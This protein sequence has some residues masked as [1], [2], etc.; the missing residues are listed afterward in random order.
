[1]H[2]QAR[3]SSFYRRCM[4]KAQPAEA[5]TLHEA[6]VITRAQLEALKAAGK[7]VMEGL[8][9]AARACLAAIPLSQEGDCTTGLDVARV[10]RAKDMALE[11][12]ARVGRD[13]DAASLEA[14]STLPRLVSAR[15]ERE[16]VRHA[17]GMFRWMRR[18][19]APLLIDLAVED[20][21]SAATRLDSLQPC[22]RRDEEEEHTRCWELA[23]GDV[24]ERVADRRFALSLE[25]F[26]DVIDVVADDVRRNGPCDDSAAF[27]FGE[28]LVGAL[29]TSS[30]EIT[31][32]WDWAVLDDVEGLTDARA[33][34]SRFR[35]HLALVPPAL[36]EALG[37]GEDALPCAFAPLVHCEDWISEL[38]ARLVSLEQQVERARAEGLVIVSR[39]IPGTL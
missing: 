23:P 10:A 21:R 31:G 2:S 6:H 28:P 22:E 19:S 13:D 8:D 9:E 17:L 18:G 27:V 25:S 34:F 30:E 37:C 39:R 7:L 36:R 24:I 14:M 5:R 32:A 29:E 16:F 26:A 4:L 38:D 15:A 35:R 1:M 33:V 11:A 20:L 3:A 12:L